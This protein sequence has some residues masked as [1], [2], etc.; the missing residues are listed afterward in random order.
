[1]ITE[2]PPR[3]WTLNFLNLMIIMIDKF[4]CVIFQTLLKS[5]EDCLNAVT[6]CSGLNVEF[7]YGNRAIR[8]T[9]D[10][11][12]LYTDCKNS[13]QHAVCFIRRFVDFSG[14]KV[15]VKIFVL[16]RIFQYWNSGH[17]VK[18]LEI[19]V[20]WAAFIQ[21]KSSLPQDQ[22]S[23]ACSKCNLTYTRVRILP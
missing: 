7:P 20:S 4:P 1:M 12:I 15:L 9:T 14:C 16:E 8:N 5:T 18:Y 21:S 11:S 6:I 13:M 19:N 3:V 2:L 17:F 10:C 22:I 23:W